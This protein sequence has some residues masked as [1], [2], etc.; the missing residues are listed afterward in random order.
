MTWRQSSKTWCPHVC[1]GLFFFDLILGSIALAL[2][3]VYL[4]VFHPEL[5]HP[6]VELVRR[7]GVL[8]LVF[9]AVALRAATAKSGHRGEWLRF[10]A[11]LRLMDVPADIVYA[12]TA[13]GALPLGM[14]LLWSAPILNLALASYLYWVSLS[15]PAHGLHDHSEANSYGANGSRDWRRLLKSRSSASV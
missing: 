4:L 12:A 5:I 6:Q 10:L 15:E 11:L 7:T 1:W 14:G 3:S 2:P 9:A 13:S 8:W